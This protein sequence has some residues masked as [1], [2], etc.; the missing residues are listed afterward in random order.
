MFQ[1]QHTRLANA[2]VGPHTTKWRWQYRLGGGSWVDMQL[3]EHRI[4]VVVALPTWR[5]PL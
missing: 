1:L 2:R 3:T 4:F 5:P